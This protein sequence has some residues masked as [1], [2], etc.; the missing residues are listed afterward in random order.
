MM[1]SLMLKLSSIIL[2]SSIYA[3]ATSIQD[4]FTTFLTKTI[5]KAKDYKFKKVEILYKEAVP[6]NK[7][8]NAYFLKIDL[9]IPS[10][11]KVISIKDIVFSNGELI[12]KDFIDIT[13]NKSIKSSFSFPAN[14]NLAKN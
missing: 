6:K 8:W 11:N 4:K 5:N 3:N 7:G 2:I 10:K 13:T 14:K 9:M 1:M 12:S